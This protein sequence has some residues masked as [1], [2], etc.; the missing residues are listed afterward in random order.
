M[1]IQRHEIIN[2][3]DE[4]VSTVLDVD[5]LTVKLES[6]SGKSICVR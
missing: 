6:P 5:V 4:N 3:I 1:K 2:F